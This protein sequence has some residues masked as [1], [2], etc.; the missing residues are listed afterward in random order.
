[1]VCSDKCNFKNKKIVVIKTNK[2]RSLLSEI[3]S[4]FLNLSQRILLLSQELMAKHLW[5]ICFQIF[6]IINLPVASIGTLGIKYKNKIIK[7]NLTSPDTITL[8]KYLSYLKKRKIDNVIIEASSHKDRSKEY[9]INSE[10]A[11]FT[12]FSQDHLDYHKTMKS[13]LNTKLVLLKK[14]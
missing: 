1:M 14:F 10:A 3:S 5:Q 13:Y 12:N 9:H 11:I 4:G 7:T 6:R 2:I 8:H